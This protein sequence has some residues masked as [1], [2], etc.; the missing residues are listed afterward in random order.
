MRE[1]KLQGCPG[2]LPWGG[3]ALTEVPAGHLWSLRKL[4]GGRQRWRQGGPQGPSQEGHGANRGRWEQWL[5]SR[6]RLE[7]RVKTIC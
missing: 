1:Q 4:D 3:C 7:S 2:L 5:D 6:C